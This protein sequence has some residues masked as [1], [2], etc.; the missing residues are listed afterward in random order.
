MWVLDATFVGGV[1]VAA[2]AVLTVLV[3]CCRSPK[4]APP[5]TCV[6]AVVVV[7]AV[8]VVV[9][10]AK[11]F[12]TMPVLFFGHIAAMLACWCLMTSGSVVYSLASAWPASAG[13]RA[14]TRAV[15]A[16]AQSLAFVCAVVGYACIFRNHQLVHG[17]QFGFDKGNPVAKTVHAL[18]GYVV[19]AWMAL[20]A[21]QGW[22]KYLGLGLFLSHKLNGRY[23]V[24]LTAVN[25]LI[26]LTAMGL[27]DAMLIGLSAGVLGAS[28]GAA[29]LAGPGGK[30]SAR[31]LPE[32]L[33]PP[34]E[35]I[36][37][38]RLRE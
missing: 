36:L 24:V 27:S 2:L 6:A 33:Q 19:L 1:V 21:C 31:E 25:I 30:A 10:G 37:Y 7:V 14:K 3:A 22:L 26:V 32:L 4:G 5:I 15:H 8:N 38:E 13:L 23:L 18:L 17:S 29:F 28:L 34:E 20:Q 12:S 11:H 35:P 16:V 9:A